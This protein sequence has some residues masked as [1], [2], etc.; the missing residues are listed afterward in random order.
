[1]F[2]SHRRKIDSFGKAI[3]TL[4]PVL[5][6]DLQECL[7]LART[8]VELVGLEAH[9]SVKPSDLISIFRHWN[10]N[11]VSRIRVAYEE[12]GVAKNLTAY[13]M[14]SMLQRCTKC[15]TIIQLI[16]LNCFK[17]AESDHQLQGRTTT[18]DQGTLGAKFR[19]G[20]SWGICVH[21]EVALLETIR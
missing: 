1:M 19:Y 21:D 14:R 3:V 5:S 6:N 15:A 20:S 12:T 11:V 10:P 7:L 2:L 8:H 16:V 4:I 9:A 17:T 13:A 18:N